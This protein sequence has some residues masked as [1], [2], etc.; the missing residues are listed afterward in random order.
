MGGK[1]L[2]AFE[3][4]VGDMQAVWASEPDL[5]SRM[6]KGKALLER[7]TTDPTILAHSKSWPFTV[8]QNL[9]LHEDELGF[10]VNAVVRPPGY[11]GGVH[12]HAHA[13]VL[14]GVVDG[15]EQLER[16]HRIDD[17]S[18]A[19]HA[20]VRLTGVTTGT[21]G[22]VDL[23]PPFDIHAEQG[24]PVRSVALIVR[25]E[26]LV[27]KTLQ[28]GYDKAAKSVVQRSGP[29]QVPFALNAD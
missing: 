13:Y 7:L 22:V 18:R 21:A 29:A 6:L 17:G 8:G 28:N 27:G 4:F 19:G 24:G 14:Y 10:V 15:T 20:Q 12:D 16:Y 3:R 5:E 26:R 25:S 1:R 9:L 11:K 23:V 2:P